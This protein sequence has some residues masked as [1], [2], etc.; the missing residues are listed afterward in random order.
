MISPVIRKASVKD[1]ASIVRIRLNALPQEEIR[2]FS[3]PEFAT[4]SSSEAL[5]KAWDRENR[6][7]DGFEVFVAEDEGKIVGFI[8]FK[9]ED[10]YGYIDNI[11]V[12]KDKQREGVGKALV[13]FAESMAESKGCCLMKTDTTENAEGVAWKSYGFWTNLGYKDTGERLP[14]DYDFKEI[15]LTKRLK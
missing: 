11:V 14:T 7:K 5:Q 4:Y 2:G 12:A 15:P 10:S 6:L 3:A 9:I 8:A 1:I 13:A